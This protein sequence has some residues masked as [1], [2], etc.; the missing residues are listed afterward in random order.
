EC[1]IALSVVAEDDGIALGQRICGGVV[2]VASAACRVGGLG[3]REERCA[4]CV[5]LFFDAI[6]LCEVRDGRKTIQHPT[7]N[8]QR[9]SKLQI[10]K[11]KARNRSE[12]GEIRNSKLET[13]N[14][15]EARI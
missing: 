10:A 15:P 3:I 4:E 7:S 11:F 6:R 9:S 2:C 13:R 1:G 14:K 8:I 5:L 12:K